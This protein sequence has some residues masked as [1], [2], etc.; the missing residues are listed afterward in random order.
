[1]T[2]KA[3]D[4]DPPES[5][6]TIEYSIVKRVDGANRNYFSIDNNT[7]VIRTALQIDRDEPTQQKEFY[8]TVKAIDN[9]N[10]RLEDICTFKITVLDINDNYP[11]FDKLVG[12]F[13]LTFL[14]K[15]RLFFINNK[16]M[17]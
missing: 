11:Q 3:L 12:H 13:A 1:M 7:G 2:V 4:E 8:L 16:K 17:L 14:R 6:G 9:G 5:G 10:P 15:S